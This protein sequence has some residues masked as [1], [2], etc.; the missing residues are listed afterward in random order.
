MLG[1]SC[2][3]FSSDD[4]DDPNVPSDR[5]IVD[6]PIDGIEIAVLESFPP[7][8]LVQIKSG[9]PS[10]CAEYESAG[11]VGRDGNTIRIRVTNTMPADDPPCDMSYRTHESAVNIGSDFTS[12]VTYTVAVNDKTKDFTAQ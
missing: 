11:L 9:L 4:A 2:S 7:Q 1:A 10:G 12:G 8:Y 5:V 6:A 3:I